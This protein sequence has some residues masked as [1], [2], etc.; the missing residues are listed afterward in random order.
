MIKP[1]R[2]DYYVKGEGLQ[3]YSYMTALKDYVD[4][5][6]RKEVS[7]CNHYTLELIST[8]YGGIYRCVG[9]GK[10]IFPKP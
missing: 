8:K 1:K 5:L 10:N 6:E 3:I 9:C 4:Y 7:E 2:E